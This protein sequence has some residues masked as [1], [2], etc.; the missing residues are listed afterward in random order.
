MPGARALTGDGP[1]T[2]VSNGCVTTTFKG[3]LGRSITFLTYGLFSRA[4]IPACITRPKG[5]RGAG[6]TVSFGCMATPAAT[7]AAACSPVAIRA[8]TGARLATPCCSDSYSGA[9][10]GTLR[11]GVELSRRPVST[12]TPAPGLTGRGGPLVGPPCPFILAVRPAVIRSD[13]IFK[14]SFSP[15]RMG[16]VSV[17]IG[18]VN[19][20]TRNISRWIKEWIVCKTE[21][22][23]VIPRIPVGS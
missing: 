2:G 16:G 6:G 8:V 12:N 20:I 9:C 22:Y 5:A 7:P 18:R 15:R 23:T 21:M 19:G 3:S 11:C 10:F 1:V 13:A 17:I 14:G 4:A